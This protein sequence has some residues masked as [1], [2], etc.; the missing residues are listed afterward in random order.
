MNSYPGSILEL[1]RL[2]FDCL[3]QSEIVEDAGP[4]LGSDP[5][6]GIQCCVSQP[7]HGRYLLFQGRDLRLV[8]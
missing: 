8:S 3:N 1:P 7:Q 5:S 4:Q 6:D 2:P